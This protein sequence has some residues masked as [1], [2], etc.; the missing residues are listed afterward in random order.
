MQRDGTTVAALI[1][2]RSLA[3]DPELIE[4]VGGAATIA[5]ENRAL[6]DLWTITASPLLRPCGHFC[7]CRRLEML[8]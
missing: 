7:G 3:D 1:Y 5:L 6:L 2:D 8:P 4:A